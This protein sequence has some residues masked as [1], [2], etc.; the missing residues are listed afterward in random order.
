M[1]F[2]SRPVLSEV[3]RAA[4]TTIKFRSRFRPRREA[5]SRVSCWPLPMWPLKVTLI[6][7]LRSPPSFVAQPRVDPQRVERTILRPCYQY[8]FMNM[9]G[10]PTVPDQNFLGLGFVLR[11]SDTHPDK[12]ALP[13]R[14]LFQSERALSI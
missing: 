12:Q 11:R 2:G 1:R 6:I 10:L 5:G 9:D 7:T 4:M 14:L 3:T 8:D 13:F